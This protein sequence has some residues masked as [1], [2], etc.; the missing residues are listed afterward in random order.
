MAIASVAIF[1]K[2]DGKTGFAVKR[3]QK[4]RED[5]E[6]EYDAGRNLRPVIDAPQ[7]FLARLR[8]TLAEQ[9]VVEGATLAEAR[10]D[11]GGKAYYLLGLRLRRGAS[12]S[13][14]EV[15]RQVREAL[16]GLFP[17]GR[18]LQCT[19]LDRDIDPQTADG[20]P[21]PYLVFEG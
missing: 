15:E 4:A 14:R 20:R 3:G 18:S 16:K 6:R 21:N 7:E 11:A 2:K 9:R 19:D 8:Q 12:V 5:A 13:F 10:D 1:K 17:Y